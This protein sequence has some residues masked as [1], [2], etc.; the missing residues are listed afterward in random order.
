MLIQIGYENCLDVPSF[1]SFEDFIEEL[2]DLLGENTYIIEK[3][4]KKIDLSSEHQLID[5]E[6]YKIWPKVLG[7]KV[8]Y[9]KCKE[10]FFLLFIYILGWFWFI[11]TFI[12]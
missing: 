8:S 4:G 7:G 1:N 10:S 12:W 5:D 9:T 3:N 2:N 6:T 11:I